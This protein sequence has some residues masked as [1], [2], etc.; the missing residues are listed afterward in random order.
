MGTINVT[1]AITHQVINEGDAVVAIIISRAEPQMLGH[2]STQQYKVSSL[3]IEGT[4]DGHRVVPNDDLTFSSTF[5]QIMVQSGSGNHKQIPDTFIDVQ[6]KIAR[7]PEIEGNTYGLMVV[8]ESTVEMLRG[9]NQ[10]DF[11]MGGATEISDVANYHVL[12]AEYL[13]VYDLFDQG[14]NSEG[15]RRT[16]SALQE[17]LEFKSIESSINNVELPMVCSSLLRDSHCAFSDRM[18]DML[19]E[20]NG[21][22]GQIRHLQDYRELP[23]ETNEVV[24]KLHQAQFIAT[25]LNIIGRQ[26]SPSMTT[27]ARQDDH[28]NLEIASK[29]VHSELK[30]KLD[31]AKESKSPRFLG[32]IDN[33]IEALK[34]MLADVVRQRKLVGKDILAESGPATR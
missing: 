5:N 7:N 25:A 34:Q 18:I 3:P 9:L 1:D 26:L 33:E 30:A 17:A 31:F 27:V 12:A 22:Q 13:R 11:N 21:H 19:D 2:S 29:V 28:Y 20:L 16:L 8:R 23:R 6:A 10:M 32:E 4:W 24:S 15:I 14:D